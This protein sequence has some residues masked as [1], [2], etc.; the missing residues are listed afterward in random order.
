M[1]S[2]KLFSDAHFHFC[3]LNQHAFKV[4]LRLNDFCSRS[5]T[6]VRESTC[7]QCS[8]FA[9]RPRDMVT[10]MLNHDPDG[11]RQKS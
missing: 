4:Y 5:Q 9:G 8:G 6:P 2:E 11:V 10:Y 3:N 1:K 7:R